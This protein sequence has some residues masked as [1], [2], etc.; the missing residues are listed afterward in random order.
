MRR[1]SVG[2]TQAQKRRQGYQR[3]KEVQGMLAGCPPLDDVIK[4]EALLSLGLLK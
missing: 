1:N 3:Q 4:R 2:R